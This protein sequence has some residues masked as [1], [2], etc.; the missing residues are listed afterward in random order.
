MDRQP[1][2]SIVVPVYNVANYVGACLD[3]ILN[4]SYKNLEIILVDDGSTD[5]SGDVCDKYASE[6]ENIIIVHQENGGLSVARNTGLD[7]VTGEFVTFVDSDDMIHREYIST[8]YKYIEVERADISAVSSVTIQDGD[9]IP[10]TAPRGPVKVFYSGADAVESMLYQQGFI[11]N[12][13]WGKLYKTKLFESHRF[14]VG[15]LY[16]DLATIPLVCLGA[17]NIVASDTPMYFYRVREDSI[18]GRFTLRRA[19]VLDVVD[20]MVK[21]MEQHNPALVDAARSRKFSANMNI[22]RLMVASG[23][24]DDAIVA[25]CWENISQLRKFTIMHPQVRL[26]NKLG[27][28]ASL[29]G[30]DFLMTILNRFKDKLSETKS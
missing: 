14:P 10:T 2:I 29:F 17:K 13:A 4:Q 8:L 16:E 23:I 9:L 18:L 28:V 26:K 22:L 11:D 24:K 21:H 15:M 3:S 27:A 30:L 20:D 5:G 7:L 1:L 6:N 12:S 25:R 19:H